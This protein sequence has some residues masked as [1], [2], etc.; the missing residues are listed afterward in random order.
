[1][2]NRTGEENG[3]ESV[4]KTGDANCNETRKEDGE[5]NMVINENGG[6]GVLDADEGKDNENEN[7]YGLQGT[8]EKADDGEKMDID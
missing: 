7:D 2:R 3:G 5:R 8:V 6:N 1:M 4:C